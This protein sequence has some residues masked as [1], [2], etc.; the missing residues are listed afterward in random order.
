MEPRLGLDLAQLRVT[1]A[2][3]SSFQLKPKARAGW[4][5]GHTIYASRLKP[6]RVY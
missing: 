5:M 2:Q 3:S 4:L 1:S 6:P